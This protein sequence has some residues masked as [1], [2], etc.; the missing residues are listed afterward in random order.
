MAGIPLIP[1]AT[2]FGNPSQFQAR[3][4]PDG[5]WLTWLAPFE[6][7]LNV[8]RRMGRARRH[9]AP[10]SGGHHR[11]FLWRLR[12]VGRIDLHARGILLR[13]QHRRDIE[14]RDPAGEHAGLLGWL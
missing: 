1:R 3:I 13:R 7:V 8:W 6:G 9:R 11:R 14:P 4:S 2:L 10:R 12:D 5:E